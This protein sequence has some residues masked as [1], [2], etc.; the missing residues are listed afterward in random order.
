MYLKLIC[1]LQK[2]KKRLDVIPNIPSW[3]EAKRERVARVLQ[4]LNYISSEDTD[5]EEEYGGVGP[6][7]RKVRCLRW[8][9]DKLSKY[10]GTLDEAVLKNSTA[11]QRRG[12][13]KVRRGDSTSTRMPPQTASV[14]AVRPEYSDVGPLT[15]TP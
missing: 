3:S 1:L 5:S 7:P 10:K 11:R 14:W 8:E 2:Q 9:S 6:K 12:M 15:S 13:A 4:D